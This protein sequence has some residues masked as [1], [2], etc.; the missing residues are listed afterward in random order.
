V[1]NI[2]RVD[3]MKVLCASCSENKVQT[4]FFNGRIPTEDEVYQNDINEEESSNSPR[5]LFSNRYYT[6]STLNRIYSYII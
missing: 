5:H 4:P 1:R 3:K 2:K 6:A